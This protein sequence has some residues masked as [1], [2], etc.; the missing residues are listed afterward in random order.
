MAQKTLNTRIRL[1][2]D[3]LENWQTNNPVLLAGEV[4]IVSIPTGTDDSGFQSLPAI[5]IKVGD[6]TTNF[7]TL[8]YT[9]AIAGDVYSWAKAATKPTYTASEISGLSDFIGETISDTN[10]KYQIVAGSTPTSIKLQSSETGEA[11][12]TDVG[13]EISITY[14]L[15]TGTTNGTVNFNGS[16]VSVYGLKSAA[17]AEASAFDAAGTAAGVQTALT[18]T[19]GDPS[20]TLTLNGIKKFVQEVADAA[21][22]AVIGTEGD[23]SSSDTI[24]G[25][26]KYTDEQIAAKV[27]SVYKPAG[28]TTFESLPELS[29]AIEGN[30]YNITNEFTTTENFVEGAGSEYPVGTNIVCIDVGTDEYK[31]DVLAG[32]L[33]LSAYATSEALTQAINGAKTELIGSGDAT[34]TTIKGAVAEAKGYTDSKVGAL[35]T[36]NVNEGS[37]NLYYT[38]NRATA[39][40][41]THSSKELTD[42]DDIVYESDTIIINCGTSVV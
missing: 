8:S 6:G 15:E 22:A 17:Y 7:N 39:N 28:S 10:T 37:T 19:A 35:T 41:K 24:K 4:A 20:S 3:T 38:E 12:W 34:S 16:P 2:Y 18:G 31:W 32:I 29:A 33:D 42:T 23:L 40:F 25:A 14:T 5:A 21:K 26:K 1:K 36:D 30:V 13:S 27:A 9:Q 11:P